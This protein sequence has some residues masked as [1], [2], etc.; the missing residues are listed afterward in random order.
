MFT[1][2]E[3]QRVETVLFVQFRIQLRRSRLNDYDL[4]IKTGMLVHFVDEMICKGAE[5]ISVT[6]LQDALRTF[7][8]QISV[9]SLRNQGVVIKT[10]QDVLISRWHREDHSPK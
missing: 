3:E 5:K 1:T 7:T 9:I 2:A 10:F 4:G 8:Q 6:E